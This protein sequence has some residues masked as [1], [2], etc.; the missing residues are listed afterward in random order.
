VTEAILAEYREVLA[1]PELKIRKGLRLQ[2]LQ[3]IR[4]RSHRV[5]VVRPLRIAKDPAIMT[6]DCVK[7]MIASAEEFVELRRS[8]RQEEYSRGTQDSAPREVWLEVIRRFPDMRFWVAQ[9]KTVPVE[10]LALLATD[11]DDSVRASLAHNK[12][13]PSEILESLL[14]DQSQIVSARPIKRQTTKDD[15]LPQF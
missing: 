9:N 13:I 7:T 12:K 5:R 10:V 1:R 2:L 3:F 8:E 15:H 14:A 6:E 11:Q 4:H